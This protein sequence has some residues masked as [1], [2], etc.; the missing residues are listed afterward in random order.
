MTDLV[1]VVVHRGG[2]RGY[3]LKY[4]I[5]EVESASADDTVTVGELSTV[6]DTVAFEMDTG[7]AV[8]CTESGNVVTV[9]PSGSLSSKPVVLMVSGW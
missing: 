1:E 6:K 2:M 8:S 4:L 5:V 9:D 7:A 3:G